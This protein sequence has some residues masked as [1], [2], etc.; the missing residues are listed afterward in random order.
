MTISVLYHAGCP[1][2]RP[3]IKLVHRCI[4][5]LGIAIAVLEHEGDHPSPTV[6]VNGFDVMGMPLPP[7]RY[8]RLDVPTEERVLDALRH[9]RGEIA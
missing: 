7:G 4:T 8:C 9:A 1:H 2:A 3:A 5:R 6:L